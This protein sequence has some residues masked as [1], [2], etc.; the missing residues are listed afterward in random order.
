MIN[1]INIKA[2][3]FFENAANV[4]V[5][6]SLKGKLH[7]TTACPIAILNRKVLD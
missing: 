3:G 1:K 7:C 4:G 6:L 2:V 5:F